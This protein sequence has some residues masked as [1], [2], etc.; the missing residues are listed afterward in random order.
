MDKIYVPLRP[1]A[2]FGESVTLR[3]RSIGMQGWMLEAKNAEPGERR[4]ST[5]A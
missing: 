5:D 3:V 2:R 1:Y 4:S